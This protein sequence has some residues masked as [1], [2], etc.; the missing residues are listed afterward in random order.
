MDNSVDHCIVNGRLCDMDVSV[1]LY[2]HRSFAS[3]IADFTCTAIVQSNYL[4][5]KTPECCRP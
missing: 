3:A 2:R 5:D 1:G 4:V